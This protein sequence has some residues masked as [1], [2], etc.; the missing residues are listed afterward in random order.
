MEA[1]TTLPRGRP[2]TRADLERIP[3]DGHRYELVDGT[4]VV[5]PAPS[6]RPQRVSGRLQPPAAQCP[7]ELEVLYAPLDLTLAES[8]VRQPDLLVAR[9][10]DLTQ[11]GLADPP[12]WRSR[13]SRPAHGWST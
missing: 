13:S 1:V 11:R 10:A 4:L 2:L 5:T 9:R 3:D 8:T 12:C 6:W 7:D